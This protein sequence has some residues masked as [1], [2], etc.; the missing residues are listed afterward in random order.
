MRFLNIYKT[1]IIGFKD[2]FF[3]HDKGTKLPKEKK[4]IPPE[5]I[6]ASP[7]NN[8][9]IAVFPKLTS[10][11]L[12]IP[13]VVRSRNRRRSRRRSRSRRGFDPVMRKRRR[14]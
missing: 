13:E 4:T 6:K 9:S 14:W 11:K 10:V 7:M 1:I 3:I 2:V 12:E 8:L 5:Y